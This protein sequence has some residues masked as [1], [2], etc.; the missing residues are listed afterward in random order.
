MLHNFTMNM[1]LTMSPFIF[2]LITAV[3]K[4]R[5]WNESVWGY[6]CICVKIGETAAKAGKQTERNAKYRYDSGD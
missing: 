5:G 3:G 2:P 4:H 6:G 1:I